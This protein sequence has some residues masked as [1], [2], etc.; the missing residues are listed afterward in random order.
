MN[1]AGLCK[2]RLNMNPY[3]DLDDNFI[4]NNDIDADKNY[5]ND[6]S[7]C[8]DYFDSTQLNKV[9]PE[10]QSSELQSMLHI[11]ARSLVANINSLC[12]NLI[13]V[14]HK[15]SVIA[16]TETWTNKTNENVIHIPGYDMLVKSRDTNGGGVAL[17][18]DK[19]LNINI[20]QRDDLV[21]TNTNIMECMFVQVSQTHLKVKDIIIGVV[22]RP[23]NTSIGG[24]F[25]AFIPITDKIN[26]E[27]RP[28]YILGD[29]NIN[30]LNSK[31]DTQTFVNQLFTNGFYPRIDRPRRVTE[32]SATLIDNIFTNVHSAD[33]VSG[34]WIADV[35][36]HLPIYVKLPYKT[37]PVKSCKTFS[38][39]IYSTDKMQNFKK[40]VSECDWEK[41]VGNENIN[42]KYNLFINKITDLHN[43]HFPIITCKISAKKRS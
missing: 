24:F 4:N 3:E 12:I 2:Q 33:V 19:N 8:N 40:E 36:D 38:R 11:N 31:N 15:F 26:K 27:K 17:Y 1:I 21:C 32:H 41:I 22:Y 18:F 25:Y 39:R 34:V 20:K 14:N 6:I 16:V 42:N 23:P 7:K 5:Y 37:E 30:L 13:T 10:F 9:L 35:A 28:C 43:K 29:F